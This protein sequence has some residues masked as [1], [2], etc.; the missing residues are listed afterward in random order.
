VPAADSLGTLASAALDVAAALAVGAALTGA[1]LAR[2]APAQAVTLRRWV[3]TAVLVALPASAVLLWAEAAIMAEVP[4]DAAGPALRLVVTGTHYGLA[5]YLGVGALA[6]A[7]LLQFLPAK[8]SRWL[9][10][11]CLALF[12]YTR[13]MISHAASNGDLSLAML[14][15]WLHLACASAWAGCVAVAGLMVLPRTLDSGLAG[16]A[17]FAQWLSRTATVALGGIVASG[18]FNAWHNLGGA[19]QALGSDYAGLLFLKIVLVLVAAALGGVNRLFVMPGLLA[20]EQGSSA[21]RNATRTFTRIL[22]V[23]TALLG[24]VLVVAAVLGSTPPPMAG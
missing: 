22:R 13:A 19:E 15:D 24:L 9:T 6:A 5:W 20:A 14:A 21:A 1:W 18:L 3:L 4:L 11:P 8:I 2:A 10:L 12:L 17:G 23:E 7:A 16:A